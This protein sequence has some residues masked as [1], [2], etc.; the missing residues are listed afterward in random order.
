MLQTLERR[1]AI[2]S[3]QLS[4]R[5]SQSISSLSKLDQELVEAL[6]NALTISEQKGLTSPESA[7]AWDIVE[8]IMRAK[9]RQRTKRNS[10]RFEQ[11]CL[12]H[13]DAPESRIYDV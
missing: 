4:S 13:P 10:T 7:V 11:Y 3:T 8:E 5:S 12:E 6:E 1:P 2:Q 9:S